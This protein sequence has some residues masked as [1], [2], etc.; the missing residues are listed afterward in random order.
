MP[1]L[2]TA[3]L[4]KQSASDISLRSFAPPQRSFR[5]HDF[6]NSTI[7][8]YTGWIQYTFKWLEWVLFLSSPFHERYILIRNG[9][10]QKLRDSIPDF[11]RSSKARPSS[12]IAWMASL[13]SRF[14]LFSPI[15]P[16]HERKPDVDISW[17][18]KD[19]PW[20][21]VRWRRKVDVPSLVVLICLSQ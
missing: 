13:S 5:Y 10:G 11:R 4:L 20:R 6:L 14:F 2:I 1:I 8:V 3:R 18:R 9:F 7:V 15:R 17:F 16:F 21:V 19:E 12:M